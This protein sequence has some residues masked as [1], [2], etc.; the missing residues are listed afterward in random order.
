MGAWGASFSLH[1]TRW[2]QESLKLKYVY[3]AGV[4]AWWRI[5]KGQW[6]AL[7]AI[8]YVFSSWIKN[9]PPCIGI[10]ACGGQGLLFVWSVSCMQSSWSLALALDPWLCP[11][12]VLGSL[13]HGPWVLLIDSWSLAFGTY[14]CHNSADGDENEP[15][16]LIYMHSD[17][18]ILKSAPCF[19]ERHVYPIKLSI[20]WHG[21]AQDYVLLLWLPLIYI[22]IY[23]VKF[24]I[25]A[26]HPTTLGWVDWRFDDDYDGYDTR[27]HLGGLT[28]DSMTTTTAMTQLT[29]QS[30]LAESNKNPSQSLGNSRS[31]VVEFDCR[32]RE[33]DLHQ[34]L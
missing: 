21:A 16:H 10:L 2:F 30:M 12:N 29:R 7:L 13:P 24:K 32:M 20:H 6:L 4:E 1:G 8:C 9:C 25:I 3:I 28:G 17:L 31:M 33:K 15:L 23:M 27:Q 26:R 34:S 18:W 11:C 5:E 14:M 22:Y 19:I